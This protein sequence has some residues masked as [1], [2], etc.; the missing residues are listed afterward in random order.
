MAISSSPTKLLEK[1]YEYLYEIPEDSSVEVIGHTAE[2][3]AVYFTVLSEELLE[4]SVAVF[5]FK[6]AEEEMN[7]TSATLQDAFIEIHY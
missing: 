7:A 5:A 6:S 4:Y 3:G 2:P 1:Q